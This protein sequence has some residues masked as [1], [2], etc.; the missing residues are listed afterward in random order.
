MRRYYLYS[1]FAFLWMSLF[2]SMCEKAEPGG[3]YGI[4]VDQ[5]SSQPIAGVEVVLT[6]PS[7]KTITNDS[8]YY[9]LSDI[10]EK[11][12]TIYYIYPDYD[13]TQVEMTDMKMRGKYQI[14]VAL[15]PIVSKPSF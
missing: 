2:F 3:I 7:Y 6:V 14:D 10:Q 12:Y 8:G 11:D 1:A 13:T 9:A 4:V 5:K 15:I